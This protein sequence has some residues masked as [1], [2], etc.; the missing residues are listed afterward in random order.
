[1]GPLNN[2]RHEA[3]ARAL[4]EGHSAD[5]A[6]VKAGYSENRGNASRLKANESVSTR[7]A[8]LQAEAAK[9]S[10][11][12]VASLL[13]ELEHA[14][15]RADSLDQLSAS[16]KAIEAKAK[17]SGL[18]VQRVEVNVNDFD[19]CETMEAIA[20]KMALDL[21]G[22]QLT[23]YELAEF[24]DMIGRWFSEGTAALRQF[25]AACTAKPVQQPAISLNPV[26]IER[27]RLGL[28]PRGNGQPR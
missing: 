11:V 26:D 9:S 28:L 3:F 25:L 27:K 14:R 4:F 16:V 8:E 24:E 5:E 7:V 2:P 10:E 17:V 15:Q 22:K 20:K 13:A 19:A 23:G 6:Y 12:T 1:M 21:S 18:L